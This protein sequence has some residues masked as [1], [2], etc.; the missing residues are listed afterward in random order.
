MIFEKN[1]YSISEIIQYEMVKRSDDVWYAT[2]Y[3]VIGYRRS[4]NGNEVN[5]DGTPKRSER[6]APHSGP[7]RS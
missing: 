6:M 1:T 7:A 4:I 5:A 2:S 3:S